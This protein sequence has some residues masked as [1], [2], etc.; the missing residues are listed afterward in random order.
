MIPTIVT[1]TEMKNNFG[2]YL[3]MV[4][5]GEEI[6]VTKN[7]REVARFVPREATVSFLSDSLR[8][9]LKGIDDPDNARDEA[10]REKYEI[11]D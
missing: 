3:D 1:A 5:A 2:R 11:T 9:I 4:M 8:G 7:G 10:L 6:V